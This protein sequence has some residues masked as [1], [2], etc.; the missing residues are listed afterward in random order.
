MTPPI[1]FR[2]GGFEVTDKALRT[3]RKTYRLAQIEYVSVERPLLIVV[4]P[5]AL[6]LFGVA[7]AFNRYLYATETATLI[8]VGVA[9]A[10]VGLLFGALRV[11]SLALRD[12]DVATSLGLVTT[13]R[14]VRRAV[15]AAMAPV[16]LD[17]G[18]D[19]VQ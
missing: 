8:A 14:K 6:G 9:G 7:V 12:E 16:D 15:E 3:N 2:G 1:F 13:L 10:L 4:F 5:L 18:R 17:E 11:H 19:E